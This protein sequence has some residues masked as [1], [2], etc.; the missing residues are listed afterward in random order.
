MLPLDPLAEKDRNY[1]SYYDTP[2]GQDVQKK[3]MVTTR[4]GLTTG[5]FLGTVDVLHY[6]RAVGFSNIIKRYMRHMVPLGMIGATFAAVANGVQHAR[7][8]DDMLNYFVGG[9]AC[10]P[11]AGIL[12]SHLPRGAAGRAGSR[13][14]RPDQERRGGQW[15]RAHTDA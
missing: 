4:Y 10:G 11:L 1:Y 12:L 8:K 6:S 5:F 13:H 15:L 3:I 9:M 2:D 7:E 14:R